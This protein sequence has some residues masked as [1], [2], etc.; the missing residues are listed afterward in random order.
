MSTRRRPRARIA[1]AIR[2]MSVPIILGWLLVTAATNIVVPQLEMVGKEH[3]VSLSPQDA[4]A[5]IAMKRLGSRFEQFDSDSMA[6]IVLEGEQPLADDA[7]RYYDELVR[8]LEQDTKHVQ[9]VQNYWGDL[10]TAAGSQSTD[11]KAAY[12]QVNLA[13]NHG[14]TLGNESVEA[15]REIVDRSHP[16]AGV[17]AYVTGQAP[18][19]TDMTEAGDKSMVKITVITLIVITVMLLIVYR[20]ITT[21]LLVHFVVLIEMS[22]A[23][24]VVEVVGHFGLL[25][26][27]TFATSL[28]TSLAI[29]A[30]TD[31][32]IF[33]VGRYQ[34]ARQSGQ[35]RQDGPVWPDNP[36]SVEPGRLAR[37]DRRDVLI[38][39]AAE[40]VAE[41][42]IEAV[43]MEAVA[44][45]A[46][47]SRPLVYKHFANRNELLAAVYQR[48]SALLHA[49]SAVRIARREGS[50]TSR[51][52]SD[53][54]NPSSVLRLHA[55]ATR[56]VARSGAQRGAEGS[57]R[58]DCASRCVRA[59]C[60]VPGVSVTAR[61]PRSRWSP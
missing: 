61:S 15:V 58:A 38:D 4:P 5:L 29:A 55:L 45:R 51:S 26:L 54:H 35:E 22:A 28:L 16:P 31:Y 18:L 30:G 34:E 50:W 47:V 2:L 53:L 40:L 57:R 39:A 1:R 56:G 52:R 33:L 8:R 25:G 19:T 27:S 6:M 10:I 44:E 14:E 12:V 37:A 36:R 11:G 7:H 59:R 20:S 60:R 23:R 13:G 42:D 17:K 9:H 24:G 48:E 43:S 46:G 41:G 3:S 49:D 21:T 32:A